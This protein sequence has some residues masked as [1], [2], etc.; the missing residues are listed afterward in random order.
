MRGASARTADIVKSI[1]LAR[2]KEADGAAL[3]WWVRNSLCFD[4]GLHRNA[5]TMLWSY[6]RFVKSPEAGLKSL[7]AFIDANEDAS[8][9][10]SVHRQ[11]VGKEPAPRLDDFVQ[12]LCQSLYARLED[13]C[14]VAS[15][16]EEAEFKR[17]F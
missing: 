9:L 4:L 12:E 2:L 11:S 16:P 1:D 8:M 17:S 3:M 7:L 6:D 10:K 5:R 15:G 14:A 13:C